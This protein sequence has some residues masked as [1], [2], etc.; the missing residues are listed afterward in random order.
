M[1][2][3][4]GTPVGE[5]RGDKRAGRR[6]RTQGRSVQEPWGLQKAANNPTA[7]FSQGELCFRKH[8]KNP[9]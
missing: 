3:A 6:G 1:A 7:G 8:A 9:G 5:E 4:A 2:L